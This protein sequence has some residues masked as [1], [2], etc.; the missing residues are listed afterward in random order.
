MHLTHDLANIFLVDTT[1]ATVTEQG[2]GLSTWSLVD[3]CKFLY[4]V[5]LE[6]ERNGEG[7]LA[8]EFYRGA[9]LITNEVVEG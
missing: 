7:G 6:L 9:L 2:P 5:G 3:E 4:A 1:Q 8:R